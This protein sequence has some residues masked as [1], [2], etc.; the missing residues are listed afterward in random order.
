MTIFTT[1]L[2]KCTFPTIAFYSTLGIRLYLF[3]IQEECYGSIRKQE[4]T[5]T[6]HQTR[7]RESDNLSLWRAP[8]IKKITKATI[9]FIAFANHA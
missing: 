5:M 2:L 8:A 6:G 1:G 3:Y 9:F 4:K 7:L